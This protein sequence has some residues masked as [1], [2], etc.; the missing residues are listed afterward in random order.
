[1]TQGRTNQNPS[2]RLTALQMMEDTCCFPLELL[3][4]EAGKSGATEGHGS[5]HREKLEGYPQ[6]ERWRE[7]LR[8]T[9][10]QF[11]TPSLV[12]ASLPFNPLKKKNLFNW[13][14]IA[15][16]YCST[17]PYIDMNEPGSCSSSF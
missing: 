9:E 6:D 2:L 17:M 3:S 16:Q 13:R 10:T 8:G 12:P 14:L 4:L 5:C 7:S 15:L 11:L 1:M